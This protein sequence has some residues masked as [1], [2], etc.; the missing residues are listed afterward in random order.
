MA[1]LLIRSVGPLNRGQFWKIQRVY[2]VVPLWVIIRWNRKREY[3]LKRP[4]G[5]SC[6][7]HQNN[8]LHQHRQDKRALLIVF[9]LTT[10]DLLEC[11]WSQC[12]N[13]PCCGK[14][15]QRHIIFCQIK[16]YGIAKHGQVFIYCLQFML[17]K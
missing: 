6:E 10:F 8:H 16:Q 11:K 17:S 7:D 9:V 14:T 5:N 13:V 15:F 2:K 3:M 4:L 12:Q 1:S